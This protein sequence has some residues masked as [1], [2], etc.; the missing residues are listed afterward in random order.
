MTTPETS[1]VAAAADH[2]RRAAKGFFRGSSL[3]VLGRVIS[4]GVNFVVQVLAVRYLAK[5]DYGALAWALAVA[6]TGASAVQLGLHRGLARFVPV[7]HERGAYDEMFGTMALAL[8]VAAGLGAALVL[9]VIGCRGLLERDVASDPLSVALLMI[10]IGL[11]PVQA[12]DNLLEGLLAVFAG[13]RSIFFRRYVLGPALKLAA[14]L[15][16]ISVAGSVRLLAAG[17]LVAGVVGSAIYVVLLGRVLAREGLLARLRPR[18]MVLPV[19]S[20]LGFSVP[21]LSTDLLLIFETTVAVMLLEH[22]RG[23][24][25]VAELRAVVPVAGLCL[26]VMQSFKLLYRPQAARFLGRGDH[27]GLRHLYWQSAAWVTVASFPVYAVCLY[28]A[29]PVT[30]LLFGER[31]E[32]AGVL[33]AILATGEFLN[34]SLGLNT[35]SLAVHGRVRLVTAINLL[36]AGIGLG[37]CAWLIPRHGAVGGAAATAGTVMARNTIYQTALRLTTRIGVPPRQALRVYASVVAALAAMAT[38]RLLTDAIAPTAA[39][40]VIAAPAVAWLNRRYLEIGE[41]FPELAKVPVLRRLLG[42]KAG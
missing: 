31:Y 21:L 20:L 14:V 23:T 34:A 10:V 4:I 32:S 40:I 29:G 28:L 16:V 19:R 12:L 42:D 26:I 6:A 9:G 13:A 11:A 18:R 33:L 41:T 7:H 22:F 39:A 1:Q 37:L 25:Q 30:V 2:P 35:F 27:A 3:L 36:S 17:Y 15:L 38:V 24:E 5:G 8:G